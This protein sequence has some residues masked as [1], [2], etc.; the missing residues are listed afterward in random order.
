MDKDAAGHNAFRFLTIATAITLAINIIFWSMPASFNETIYGTIQFIWPTLSM[1]ILMGIHYNSADKNTK[2][3]ARVFAIA[4]VPWTATLLLWSIILPQ[5][6]NND[7][8]YYVSGF[9]FLCSYVILAYGFVQLVRSKQWYIDPS[10]SFYL[11]VITAMVFIGVSAFI[12]SNIKPDSPRLPDIIILY[13]YL[14]MDTIMLSYVIRLLYMSLGDDLKYIVLVMGEF[15]F[16]NSIADLIFEM[17]WLFSMDYIISV[18][19]IRVT[20]FIY[21]I[22]LVFM[23]AALM[24]YNSK[25]KGRAIDEVNKKLY[26]TKHLMDSVVMQ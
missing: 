15:V 9:G 7:L 11:N 16:I 6:Y 19:T 4:L 12:L 5:L 14:F 26:D 18:K 22:S 21:N 25:F 13:L 10:R 2:F 1:L 3:I 24:M 17:R 8:A 23:V 20:D